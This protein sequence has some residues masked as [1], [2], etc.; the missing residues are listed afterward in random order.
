MALLQSGA[1]AEQRCERHP[2][3]LVA[4]F[5]ARWLTEGIPEVWGVAEMIG[6]LPP[7]Q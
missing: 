2:V 3:A 1:S 5:R 4:R 6:N 7:A